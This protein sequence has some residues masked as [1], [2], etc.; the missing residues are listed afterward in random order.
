ML[1]ISKAITSTGQANYYLDLA[2]RDDYYLEAE[3]PPGFWLGRGAQALG[4]SGTVTREAFANL[5]RGYSPDGSEPLVR[6]ARSVT[7]R[8]AWDMTWSA[9]KSVS[10][11]WSQA[12]AV[13][14]KE[15]ESALYA[16][17]GEGIRYLENLGVVSRRGENGVLRETANLIFAAFPHTTSRSQEPQLH[18]HALLLNI[19]VRADGSTGTLEPRPLFR[20]QHTAGALFRAELA[21]QLERRL[22]LRAVREGR[23][24]E[25]VGV[26]RALMAAFSTRRAEVLAALEEGGGQGARA[27]ELAVFATRT[28]KVHVPRERLFERWHALGRVHQWS[29]PEVELLLQARFPAR[30][31]ASESAS[32]RSDALR[33]LTD[34]DSHFPERNLVR[35]LAEACQGRGLGARA[36]LSLNEELQGTGRVVPVG[37]RRG[38]TQLSTPEMLDL[39]RDLIQVAAQLRLAERPGR[40]GHLPCPVSDQDTPEL[41]REQGAV[42]EQL[43]HSQGGLHLVAGLAGTGKTLCFQRAH[44]R[45][46]AQGMDVHG[47]SLSAKAATQLEEGSGIASQT[48]HRLLWGIEH[49]AL[50]LGPRSVVVVDEAAMV[51]TRQL[52]DLLHAGH[53]SGAKIVLVGDAGQLQPIGPGGAFS[54]LQQIHGA[55]QLTEIRRQR[56]PWAREAVKA[57]AQGHA[58]EAIQA[59]QERDLLIRDVTAVEQRLVADW[60]RQGLRHPQ[61]AAILAGTN[62]EVARL[63]ALAQQARLQA[64]LLSGIPLSNGDQGFFVQDRVL[65]TLNDPL[66]GV[67]NGHQGTVMDRQGP[68]LRIALDHGPEVVVDLQRYPHLRLG[69][70]YTTHKAQG[71]TVDHAFVLTGRM[72]YR[73]ITYVQASRARYST[74]FYVADEPLPHLIQRMERSQAKEMA[75]EMGPANNHELTLNP[76]P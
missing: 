38:E 64:G 20:H 43:T 65:F 2:S 12:G 29:G 41:S 19:G 57:F 37:W 66:H 62:A 32:A 36:V 10:A 47:A 4:L 9:P 61:R 70:A 53:R 5:F 60:S 68:T 30:E 26:D 63:N 40:S 52:H 39:E 1:S 7:R 18:V 46:L 76:V 31:P 15:V 45:W 8:S 34:H 28:R 59:Y 48:L 56:D 11:F 51:S 54:A 55:V 23:T 75:T 24:F 16:A 14:R 44:Q 49:D 22:G 69:Y 67:C 72:Q 27:A 33:E 3:E 74:R 21:A 25:L 73:E 35:A 58:Q 50:T 42:I 6:N 13:V 17:V 71:M